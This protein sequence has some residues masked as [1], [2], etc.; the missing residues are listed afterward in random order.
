MSDMKDKAKK[1]IDE[2]GDAAKKVA[3]HV[4][5]TNPRMLPVPRAGR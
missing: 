5:A 3:D 4:V 2:A 1:K